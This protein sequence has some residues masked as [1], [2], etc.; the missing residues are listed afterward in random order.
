ML[1]KLPSILKTSIMTPITY[2]LIASCLLVPDIMGSSILLDGTLS[3]DEWRQATS[4]DLEYEIM[5]SRNTPANLKTTA[6]IKFDKKYLYIGIKAFGDPNKIRATLKNRDQTWNEDYVALMADPFRDG[7]YGI[8]IG[9][10]ALGVQL[11]EKHISSAGPDDSWDILFQSATAFQDDGYSAE[12]MIPVSELQ[13]P[14]T[15]IQQW[16]IGFIRKSYQAGV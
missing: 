4:Y 10:N 3:P 1:K 2:V 14:D 9:V 8:L 12:F 6:Y 13:L 11:D 15:E 5:P 7:R 16:K